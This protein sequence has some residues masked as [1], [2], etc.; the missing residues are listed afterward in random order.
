MEIIAKTKDGAIIS[1]TNTEVKDILVAVFGECKDFEIGQ[2]IP[3]FD[4]GATIKKAKELFGCYEL[5]QL[6]E[7][8][9]QFN[10]EVEKL[11]EVT[12]T[13]KNAEL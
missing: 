6:F 12:M 7:Y 11:K 3:A 4:Y 10:K 13:L 8:V 9:K 5:R 1:A 2:K